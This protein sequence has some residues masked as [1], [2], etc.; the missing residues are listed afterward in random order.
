VAREHLGLS[1]LGDERLTILD[2][3]TGTG[4][5]LLAVAERVREA[6]LARGGEARAALALRSLTP[7]MF[8]FELLVGPYAVAHY[9]LHHALRVPG[10]AVSARLGVYLTDTLAPPGATAPLGQLGFLARGIRDEREAADEVKTRRPVLAII[11]NPPYRRLEAGETRTLVGPWMDTLWDDL[12]APVRDARQ[13]NQL[14]TFPELSVAF[15][16]WAIWKLFEAEGAPRRGVVAFITNRKFL[17]GWPYAGLR[18]R[19]RE[20]FDRIEVIDLRGDARLGARAGIEG[21]ENVF[22]IMVG[23]AITVAIADGSRR[24]AEGEVLYFD[25]WA[26]A[27]A[28]RR[29][30]LDLLAAGTA[31]G[32]V[33]GAAPVGRAGLEDF[34]PRAFAEH[35]YA[36][37][38]SCFVFASSGIQT[39]RDALV[40][41]ADRVRLETRIRAF[42]AAPAETASTVFHSSRDRSALEAHRAAFDASH[43]RTIAYRPLD[44][45]T[46]YLHPRFGDFLRPEF[47]QVWGSINV[48]LYALPRGTGRGPAVWCHALLPDY[49]AFRGSYGGYA[50]PL[51]DRRA[52]GAADNLAPALVAALSAAYG[53]AL[54]PQ[55]VFDAM[56][57][58]LSASRYTQRFAEDLEDVFPHVPFPGALD[59]FT[60]AAALGARIRAA[61]TFDPAARLPAARDPAFVRLDTAPSA[62]AVLAAQWHEDGRLVLAA[63][64]SGRVSGLPAALWRFEVS[65]YPVLQRWL[66]GREG[67]DVDLELFD[68][69]RDV[70]ARIIA[71]QALFARADAILDAAIAAPWRGVHAPSPP[72][73][74]ARPR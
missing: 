58:L 6:A 44:R 49:H 41:D 11:G 36:D 38:R 40:Y 52:G 59:V 5:F 7:R 14:N 42:H 43:L 26:A 3:A 63:D 50:F 69:L 48:A 9:R 33:R 20:R 51:H 34:R 61:Q 32:R 12:K 70:C 68:A 18:R 1:G 22:D 19:M 25:S 72:P 29:A 53:R 71:L 35:G 46:V 64:G 16:R 21:D 28:S 8:G 39:K 47:Q 56:L 55:A 45:R 54:K 74:T 67:L 15:W 62:G 66:E 24:G 13:G 30:K 57:C 73:T 17:T 65:G 10:A 37:L 4:T 2:P 27:A 60:K 23:T 31:E